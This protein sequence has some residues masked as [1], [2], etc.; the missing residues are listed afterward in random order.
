MSYRVTVVN[1]HDEV[2][3]VINIDGIDLRKP[4]HQQGLG[5]QI[6][7]EMGSRAVEDCASR[8]EPEEDQ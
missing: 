2:L 8:P 1:D 4:L 7:A 3:T 6:G 5:Q